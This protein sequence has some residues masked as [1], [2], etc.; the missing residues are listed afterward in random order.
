MSRFLMCFV[1]FMMFGSHSAQAGV[2]IGGTRL[3]YDGSKKEAALTISNPDDKA[4]LI[5]SWVESAK[6]G[7]KTPFLITPPLFRLD[8]GKQ[9]VLRTIL[10]DNSLPHERESLYW[11]SIK[12]IPS[13]KR[14]DERNK[15]QLAIKTRIKLIYRPASLQDKTPLM[16]T[17]QLKWS[18]NGDYL[19]VT[20]PTPYFMNFA[21][22]NVDGDEVVDANIVAPKAN[23]MYKL[24]K[25]GGNQVSWKLI[26][27]YG[28]LSNTYSYA[29]K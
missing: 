22:V 11:M 6:K 7:E 27:D 12:S 21:E 19:Y 23:A 18:V 15:L 13:S 9:N 8:G 24:K 1:F 20:N 2:I 4:Y 29:L 10:K 26:N 14:D 5:Q 3:I 28:G 17:E 25:K 16:V